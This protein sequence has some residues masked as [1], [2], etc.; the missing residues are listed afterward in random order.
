M[1]SPRAQWC[2]RALDKR[3]QQ[4]QYKEAV[5]NAAHESCETLSRRERTTLAVAKRWNAPRHFVEVPM[6][7]EPLASAPGLAATVAAWRAARA[8]GRKCDEADAMAALGIGEMEVTLLGGLMAAYA[9]AP[10][11][12]QARV[13]PMRRASE[14]AQHVRCDA[15]IM[16]ALAVHCI[17]APEFGL[18]RNPVPR[19]RVNVIAA[20]HGSGLSRLSRRVRQHE[21]VRFD[22]AARVFRGHE[23]YT[24]SWSVLD[25]TLAAQ[26]CADALARELR[27]GHRP[28]LKMLLTHEHPVMIRDALRRYGIDSDWMLY[29]PDA[30]EVAERMAA[31]KVAASLLREMV[32]TWGA[33]KTQSAPPVAHLRVEEECVAAIAA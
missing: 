9:A 5:Q 10:P 4:E 32:G 22:R 29:E 14:R 23:A 7:I 16:A 19:R 8:A 2:M 20:T 21:A 18:V 33:L 31:R 6:D 27:A 11:E 3:W 26:R 15:G 24:R 28:R 1:A 17:H 12:L 30:K 13:P 25:K